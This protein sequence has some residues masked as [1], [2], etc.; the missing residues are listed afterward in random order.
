MGEAIERWKD[1]ELTAA[2]V[3][4]SRFELELAGGRRICIP[5]GVDAPALERLLA[6]A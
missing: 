6:V 3:A 4:E 5:V 2:V 1:T